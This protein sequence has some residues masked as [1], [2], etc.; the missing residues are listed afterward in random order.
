VAVALALLLAQPGGLYWN[1]VAV[2]A[3]LLSAVLNSWDMLIHL[4]ASRARA[5][6]GSASRGLDETADGA[7][8]RPTQIGQTSVDPESVDVPPQLVESPWAARDLSTNIR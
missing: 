4:S 7:A 8:T 3:I 6:S 1:F 5:A 2:V